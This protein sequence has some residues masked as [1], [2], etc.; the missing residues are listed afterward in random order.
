MSPDKNIAL[1]KEYKEQ[2]SESNSSAGS[3]PS[4][5]IIM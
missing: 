3:V 4:I 2:G 5:K 1:F